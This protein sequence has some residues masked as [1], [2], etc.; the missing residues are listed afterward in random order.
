MV[1]LYLLRS[2]SDLIMKRCTL[3]FWLCTHIVFL[4]FEEPAHGYT[5]P[6]E[7]IEHNAEFTSRV[8]WDAVKFAEEYGLRLAGV[9]FFFTEVSA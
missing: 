7:A 3:T 4:L 2:D 6:L 9:N 5:V 8:N 1:R